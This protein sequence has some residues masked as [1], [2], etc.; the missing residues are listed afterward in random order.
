[1]QGFRKLRPLVEDHFLS[2]YDP[3]FMG[4][5]ES[6]ADGMGVWSA[7]GGDTTVVAQ[8]GL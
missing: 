5:L 4:M 7:A 1:M 2:G 3:E 6:P 8:V